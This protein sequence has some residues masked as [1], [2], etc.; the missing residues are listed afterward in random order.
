MLSSCKCSPNFI[1]HASSFHTGRQCSR[2]KIHTGNRSKDCLVWRI[3]RLKNKHLFK[4]EVQVSV[5]HYHF[6]LNKVLPCIHCT[7]KALLHLPS[8]TGDMPE[9]IIKVNIHKRP[10]DQPKPLHNRWHPLIPP[11]VKVASGDSFRIECLDYTGGQIK[12]TDDTNDI[13][14][15]DTTIVHFLSGPIAVEGAEPGDLLAVDIL[16]MGPLPDSEWGFTA[17]YPSE[18][19]GGLL[20][21][22]Y[23]NAAKAIWKFEN[24]YATSRHIPGKSML[25]SKTGDKQWSKA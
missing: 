23:P 11:V 13:K 22:E 5:V 1:C 21:K 15:I 10:Q 17:I 12:D 14:N 16:D 9:T 4:V 2:C 3:P 24:G 20:A 25:L 18:V 7:M 6:V 8:V 19:A